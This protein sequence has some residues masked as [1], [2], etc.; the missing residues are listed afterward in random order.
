MFANDNVMSL[1]FSILDRDQLTAADSAYFSK[2]VDV[3]LNARPKETV[4][5]LNQKKVVSKL[6]RHI[7][8]YSILSIL[9]LIFNCPE[10][11]PSTGTMGMAGL[12]G[13]SGADITPI[14]PRIDTQWLVDDNV[15][16]QLVDQLDD[17][18]LPEANHT[19]AALGLVNILEE[20]PRDVKSP[21]VLSVEEPEVLKK[22]IRQA[23]SDGHVTATIANSLSV[24]EAV[25]SRILPEDEEE[26][27]AA[28]EVEKSNAKRMEGLS[29]EEDIDREKFPEGMEIEEDSSKEESKETKEPETIFG[30]LPPALSIVAENLQGIV[31]LATTAPTSGPLE[32]QS[33][34]LE[35]PLGETRLKAA[36]LLGT[37]IRANYDVLNKQLVELRAIPAL[38]DL[39]FEFE[40][41]VFLHRSIR[42]MIHNV[43]RAKNEDQLGSLFE[44][45]N[46]IEKLLEADRKSAV[47]EE[48]R[49]GMRLGYM[50]Y[51][52]DIAN[53]LTKATDER[54]T[55]YLGGDA[56]QSFVS[57]RLAKENEDNT[58]VLG[59]ARPV[60]GMTAPFDE[61][62]QL[63]GSLQNSNFMSQFADMFAQEMY[64][65]GITM[66]GFPDDEDSEEEDDS[67]DDEGDDM[68][69]GQGDG[70][71]P[72]D[73]DT[74]MEDADFDVD[75]EDAFGGDEAPEEEDTVN[76]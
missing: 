65:H 35:Q 48:E 76:Q 55:K 10:E 13:M 64:S 59:G 21:L 29:Y 4:T 66:G 40:W 7:G 52:V 18:S 9:E 8:L 42:K 73:G 67:D 31:G 36:Q 72:F 63:F 45:G 19:N 71:N 15:I 62:S 51:V 58:L 22:V 70:N 38:I 46:F 56:W 43:L 69:D 57:G 49:R 28:E 27:K 5:Y 2:V 41:N 54:I 32:M 33:F 3:L 75:F 23:L 60:M 37:L 6:I 53:D 30:D 26:K 20:T 11:Q 25:V 14:V 68:E 16:H 34:T 39:F 17:E 44:H 61:I 12:M 47:A 1:L 74:P 24:I 50:A